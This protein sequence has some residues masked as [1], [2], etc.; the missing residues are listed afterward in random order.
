MPV[1]ASGVV[2]SGVVSIGAS[3]ATSTSIAGSVS[4]S[5]VASGAVG[6]VG[7]SSTVSAGVWATGS[8]NAIDSVPNWASTAA[9]NVGISAGSTCFSIESAVPTWA[10][11]DRQ[12]CSTESSPLIL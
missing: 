3:V 9:L 6:A 1:V 2:A 12:A 8:K 10:S 5:G 11:A 4:V 7:S